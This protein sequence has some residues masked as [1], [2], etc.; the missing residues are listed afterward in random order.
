MSINI[1]VNDANNPLVSII[2]IS[3]AVNT[4]ST[5]YSNTVRLA[6]QIIAQLSYMKDSTTKMNMIKMQ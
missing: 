1:R 2:L 3:K 4:S 6:Q 5:T